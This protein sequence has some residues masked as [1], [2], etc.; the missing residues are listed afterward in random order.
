MRHQASVTVAAPPGR[1]WQILSDVN[2][3]P[4]WTP[5]VE[6]IH[7]DTEQLRVGSRVR[8]K[9]PGRRLTE[10]VVDRVRPAGRS[11]GDAAPAASPSGRITSSSPTPT[12]PRSS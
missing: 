11:L 12:A 3:W 2:A 5:T 4:Q 7:A 8:L 9:Q 6:S 10:Y 1:V